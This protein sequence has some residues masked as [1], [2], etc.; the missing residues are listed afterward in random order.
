[1]NKVKKK[2]Y[3]FTNCVYVS[4]ATTPVISPEQDKG[5][6]GH[7]KDDVYVYIAMAEGVALLVSLSLGLG[8]LVCGRKKNRYDVT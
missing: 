1:M 3:N 8:Y 5:M 6:D 2:S 7:Y 4:G